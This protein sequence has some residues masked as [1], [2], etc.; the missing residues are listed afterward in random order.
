MSLLVQIRVWISAEETLKMAE[1][2]TWKSREE[3]GKDA[4][5]GNF[6]NIGKIIDVLKY[7]VGVFFDSGLLK[8]HLIF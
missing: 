7:I 1:T 8:I 6:F 5:I 4:Y 3:T 2:C